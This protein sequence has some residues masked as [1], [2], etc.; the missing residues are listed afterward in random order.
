MRI[1]LRGYEL[2][3]IFYSGERSAVTKEVHAI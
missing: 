1:R 3:D 2:L